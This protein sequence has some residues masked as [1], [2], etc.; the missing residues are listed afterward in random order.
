MLFHIPTTNVFIGGTVHLLPEGEVLPAGLLAAVIAADDCY[1]ESDLDKAGEPT[2][3]RYVDGDSIEQHIPLALYEETAALCDRLDLAILPHHKPWWVSLVIS[4]HLSMLAGNSRVFG[5][6][7]Q[8]WDAAKRAG[9]PIYTLESM[10]A[11]QAFDSAPL[12]EQIARLEFV[13]AN[14]DSGVSI[15]SRIQDAWRRVDMLA[16]QEE[17]RW[18]LQLTPVTFSNLLAGRNRAWL[19]TILD[20]IEGRRSAFFAVGALHLAGEQSLHALLKEHGY[21]LAPVL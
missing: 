11:L 5:A 14:Q 1:F 20:A 2:I 10:D 13:I 21:G 3:A 8:L 18:N 9:K 15:L 6:D 12:E 19:P 4:S 7:M 17:L 16:L